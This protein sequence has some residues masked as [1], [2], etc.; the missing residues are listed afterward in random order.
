[1][2]KIFSL[3]FVQLCC[4]SVVFAGLNEQALSVIKNAMPSAPQGW[5]VAVETGTDPAVLQIS[6]GAHRFGYSISYKRVAG[7]REGRKQL[8]R[9]YGES[10]RRNREA[11]KPRIDELI[12]Q[13]TETS[14]ALRKA[15]RRRNVAEERRLNEDLEANGNRMRE[16]HQDLDRQ[17]AQ[18]VQPYLL[19]DAD[20]AVTVALNEEAAA[21]PQAEP[22][23][24]KGAAFA[25]YR[26][27]APSG[28][29]GWKQGELLVLYGEWRSLGN[30]VFSAQ[31]LAGSDQKA[32]TIRITIAGE[33]A[34]AQQLLNQIDLEAVLSLMK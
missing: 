32:R 17:V 9:I 1:M 21:L 34:R 29:T 25:L 12:R 31:V 23:A 6:A 33:Q 16:L 26:Q 19:R 11:V 22:I 3:I 30:N 15:V 24:V 4:W 14:L 10:A 28:A 5:T 8:D 13:Q 18:D 20:A 7:V 27:G 2:K